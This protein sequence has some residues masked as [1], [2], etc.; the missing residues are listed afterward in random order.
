MANNPYLHDLHAVLPRLLALFD[1]DATSSSVGMG[2]RFHW[3]WGLTDF[4]NGTFQGAVHGFARLWH[5]GLWPYPTSRKRFLARIDQLFQAAGVLTRAEGSLEEAFPHEGS[6]CVTALVA[7]DLLCA[8]DLLG[9]EVE[10]DIQRRWR[11]II[12]PMIGYLIRREETHAFISNHLATAVAALAR[13]NAMSPDPGAE[14]KAEILLQAI[15]EHQSTEGW[16]L[17]YEGADP[18]YQSLC[19]YYLADVHRLRPDWK[20]LEPL[21]RSIQFLWHFAHP[22]GSFGGLYGS[23]CTRFYCPAG[24][25]AL[26]VELPE[27]AALASHM[28]NSLL[29]GHVVTLAVL[30]E[31]NLVPF[32][33]A[34]CWAATEYEVREP[35]LCLPC[36]EGQGRTE[37][38]EAGLLVDCGPSHYTVISLHKGGV[39]AHF[40]EGRPAI[41][42]AGVVI[43][44]LGGALGS[45]QGFFA[46]NRVAWDGEVLSVES[47][48]TPMPKALPTPIQFLTLRVLCLSLFR[49]PS[50]REWVKRRLV[51]WLITR[52]SVWPVTNCRQV[53]LGLELTIH[54]T[55]ELPKGYERVSGIEAFVPIHM[56]SQGYWQIQDEG[57]DA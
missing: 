29:A 51:Q 53:R 32:F 40:H 19:T 4:G 52:R 43:R 17:E 35:A 31:S 37:F 50:L 8:M 7:F 5:H 20:L 13:W 45:T 56:A 15:L 21:R 24:V 22:D 38:R 1:G 9:Q 36:K 41:W 26:A 46:G 55:L 30:D 33:N 49:W 18:G 6:F 54:D 14:K 27:A 16:F 11:E 3:A 25:A 57:E 23:R 28:E 42:D 39:V 48:V 12:R 47:Q 2:D 10:P 44:Q 34:W